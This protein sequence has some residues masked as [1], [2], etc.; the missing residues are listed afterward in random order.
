[1]GRTVTGIC[2]FCANGVRI[3]LY[4][5]LCQAPENQCGVEFAFFRY[6]SSVAEK[7]EE[8]ESSL[9]ATIDKSWY[10]RP[11]NARLRTSA[12]GIV[13]RRESDH[14]LIALTREGDMEHYLLPKGGI[15]KKETLLEAARREILEEAGIKEL[16]LL[17]ELGVRERLDFDKRR[18]ITTHYFLFSTFQFDFDPADLSRDY[19]PGWFDLHALPPMLWPEQQKLIEDNREKIIKAVFHKPEEGK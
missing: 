11:V 18:W 16:F 13:V 15:E 9:Y 17:G 7:K 8:K 19:R 14:I 1:M 4:H 10:I 2:T 3:T 12:G 6:N 5:C